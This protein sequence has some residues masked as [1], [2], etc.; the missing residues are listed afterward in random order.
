MRKKLFWNG[1]LFFFFGQIYGYLV[2]SGS[3]VPSLLL[4]L[5]LGFFCIPLIVKIIGE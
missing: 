3:S 1:I 4:A 5:I 2:L